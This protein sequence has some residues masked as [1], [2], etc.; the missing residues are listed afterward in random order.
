MLVTLPSLN[1]R[2]NHTLYSKPDCSS[3]S[4]YSMTFRPKH[5]TSLSLSFWICQ[6]RPLCSKGT[7]GIQ[8]GW[9]R[10]I[11][12]QKLRAAASSPHSLGRVEDGTHLLRQVPPENV[13]PAGDAQGRG[14][15]LSVE[16]GFQHQ[17][18]TVDTT[19]GQVVCVL[20]RARHE[21]GEPPCWPEGAPPPL[22]LCPQQPG[23]DLRG[24]VHLILR[25]NPTPLF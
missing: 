2:F 18:G 5:C 22:G 13:L 25:G 17:H 24:P 20:L 12:F 11:C 7:G 23:L 19:V 10:T 16:R 14:H 6:R 1:A 3:I 21:A 8:E 15:G 9:A 4:F